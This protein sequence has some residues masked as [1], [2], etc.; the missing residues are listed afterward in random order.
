MLQKA[1][2]DPTIY[3]LLKKIV[4]FLFCLLSKV[5]VTLSL[6]FPGWPSKQIC[7]DNEKSTRKAAPRQGKGKLPALGQNHSSTIILWLTLSPWVQDSSAWGCD[8]CTMQFIVYCVSNF[9]TWGIL[10]FILTLLKV[11][12]SDYGNLFRIKNLERDFLIRNS[13][14]PVNNN[15]ISRGFQVATFFR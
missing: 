3:C 1:L 12:M 11:T 13:M 5:A 14:A 2:F 8:E 15:F 4:L 10:S 7:L 9:E 6:S